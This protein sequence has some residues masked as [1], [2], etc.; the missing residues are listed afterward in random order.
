MNR[1]GTSSGRAPGW[2]VGV[3]VFLTGA[4][5]M[6]VELLG[7]R[8]ITPVYGVG[9]HV[10][11]SLIS[12]ALAALSLGYFAG[13]LL[14]DRRPSPR[15][16]FGLVVTAAAGTAAIP[17]YAPPLIPVFDTLGQRLGALTAATVTFLPPLFLLGCAS[18]FAVRLRARALEHVGG[19]AG[20]LYALSTLGS[21]A[22]TL[23]TGFLLA[24]VL[25]IPLTLRITAAAVAAP[26]V[27]GLFLNLPRAAPPAALAI[28]AL[29]LPPPSAGRR[30]PG[31]VLFV[32]ES[33]YQ[34]V[35]VYDR[36]G[37]RWLLLDGTVHTHLRLEPWPRVEWG[38]LRGFSLIPGFRPDARRLL[39]LGVGGGALRVLLDSEEYQ[40]TMVELDP[41]VAAAARDWF[42]T[43]PDGEPIHVG[44]VRP[45]VR[46]ANETWDVAVL[47][48]C[49][50]DLM[51]E[52]LS[53]V[54]FFR[55]VKRVLTPGGLL[56][57]NSIGPT[58]GRSLASLHRTLAAAFTHVLGFPTNPDGDVTNMIFY[59]SD[60]PLTL[61]W[62]FEAGVEPAEFPAGEASDPRGIV[63]T[64]FRNPVNF[65][66][67]PWSWRIRREHE[68]RY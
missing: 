56:A 27:L 35:E 38:Y 14:A 19:T 28:A 13:G 11:A 36:E 1:A 37:E 20:R 46:R 17:L 33:P 4:A 53:T 44:D 29:F 66:N 2:L 8:L 45:F 31:E 60:E 52:H 54:E 7:V 51:P 25:E 30:P 47:D 50:S 12:V 24:P 61:S 59:A 9:L 43:I 67:A 32:A 40:F 41:L 42:G 64:D 5:V 6:V 55:E 15:L 57:M 10:W 39:M 23:A 26:G 65:W 49:G 34:R 58:D 68:E 22:G 62:A 16:F 18:P 48:V 21:V 63:L 3:S